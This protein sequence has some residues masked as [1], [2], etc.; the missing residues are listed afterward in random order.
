MPVGAPA[1]DHYRIQ[2]DDNA[3]FSSP[4]IDQNVAGITN[5]STTP[6]APL[7]ANTKFYWRVSAYNGSGQYSSWS[8]SRSFR[9]AIAPPTLS[10]PGNG[11]STANKKPVFD[12]NDPTG[13]TGYTLQISKNNTFTSL[14]GTYN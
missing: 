7:A 5:S 3:D 11:T 12:W 6:A 2:V 4:V 9:S 1:F 10:S 8:L 14:V 13:A